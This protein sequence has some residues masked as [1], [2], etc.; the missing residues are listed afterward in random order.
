MSLV[1]VCSINPPELFDCAVT[2]IPS[3]TDLPLQVVESLPGIVTTIK[4]T[5]DT[6]KWVGLFQGNPGD[7]RLVCVIAGGGAYEKQA[8]IEKGQ[9]LSLR[10]LEAE[11]VSH[12]KIYLEFCQS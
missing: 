4:V 6:G 5:E 11:P 9:R 3:N 10:S 1:L 2:P 12:G 8:R 7:E